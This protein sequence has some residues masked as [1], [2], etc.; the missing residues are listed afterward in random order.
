MGKEEVAANK[1]LQAEAAKQAKK[2]A[3]A[4]KKTKGTKKTKEITEPAVE[5][6]P[7][8]LEQVAPPKQEN[9]L[10]KQG[11]GGIVAVVTV[12]AAWSQLVKEKDG[13]KVALISTTVSLLYLIQQL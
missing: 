4:T 9:G 5:A 8:A 7:A 11:A 10:L 1:K 3:A 13:G 6:V 12:L 2:E